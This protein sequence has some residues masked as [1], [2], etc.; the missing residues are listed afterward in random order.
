MDDRTSR[1]DD[2][3]PL[4]LST[5]I[6]LP[7]PSSVAQ[8]EVMS[9]TI[10]KAETGVQSVQLK[11]NLQRIFHGTDKHIWA[12]II[13]WGS[14]FIAGSLCGR[15]F[16]VRPLYIARYRMRLAGTCAA[17]GTVTFWNM[18]INNN[19]SKFVADDDIHPI[20]NVV[21]TFYTVAQDP[22]RRKALILPESLDSV[23]PDLFARIQGPYI[24]P[25]TDFS[26]GLS[27]RI[28]WWT[29]HIWPSRKAQGAARWWFQGFLE[30]QQLSPHD[31]DIIMTLVAHGIDGQSWDEM[32][33]LAIVT[34]LGLAAARAL[35]R[36]HMRITRWL[37]YF[38]AA[39]FGA[40][41]IMSQFRLYQLTAYP[42]DIHD[43]AG[44]A[45]ALRKF[46][47]K[48]ADGG[49]YEQ[50]LNRGAQSRAPQSQK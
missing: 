36:K 28:T 47:I 38:L 16:G 1:H 43:K 14:I 30:G 13:G 19:V 48:K 44:A 22:E 31:I 20:T 12:P 21:F 46:D 7:V 49:R 4:D 50:L 41:A 42:F 29:S 6:Q 8:P 24:S 3:E 33:G 11:H 15:F 25:G 18:A 5:E 37:N 10:S 45:A 2:Y 26:S 9:A 17:L 23:I 32:G 34:T 35:A 39:S 27:Q 40:S